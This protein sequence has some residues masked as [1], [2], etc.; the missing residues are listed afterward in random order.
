MNILLALI[1]RRQDIFV[2]TNLDI[3]QIA[4]E[5]IAWE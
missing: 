3:Q 2:I 5:L 1:S 4:P